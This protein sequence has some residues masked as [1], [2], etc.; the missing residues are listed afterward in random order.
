MTTD[1]D[2]LIMGGG[3]SGMT[4]AL[5]L[6][7]RMPSLRVMVL[8]RN[9]HPVP[10]AAHKVGEST[11]EIGAHYLA[12]TLGL[13]EHLDTHHLRKFGF[14]FFF[15]DG[16]SDIDQTTEL[17]ASRYLSAPTYQIDRGMLE[18]HLGQTVQAQGMTF[19]D[20]AVVQ[21]VAMSDH[22]SLPH[23]VTW[24][25]RSQGEK[26]NSASDNLSNDAHPVHT[27]TARWVIDASGR[28]GLLKRKFQLAE[29]ND[30]SAHAIWFRMNH[31]I[32][33]DAWSQDATW[34]QRCVKPERWL[35]TNHLCGPGY[36][37]WLIPL[38]SG[39]HSVDIVADPRLQPL[40]GMNTFERAMDWIKQHQPRL[41]QELDPVRDTLQDFAFFKSFSYGCKQVFSDQR[42]AITG[43][44]GRFLDPFYS[45][46]SD[47]IAIGNT[48]ITQ[49]VADDMA[50]KDIR[51]QARIYDSTI[52]TFYESMLPIYQDQ[53]ALFGDAEVMP[54]KVIWDYAYYWSVLAPLF[55]HERLTDVALLAYAQSDLNTC[56]RLN[57]QVQAFFR[58]WNTFSSKQGS[59]QMFDQ[60]RV[61]WFVE[62][63]RQLTVAKD[64]QTVRADLHQAAKLLAQ[65]AQEIASGA[66]ARHAGLADDAQLLLASTAAVGSGGPAAGTAVSAPSVTQS[67][68]EALLHA[69]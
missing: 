16:R 18:N 24:Q 48:Y 36:W 10:V 1:T 53:Y 62:L 49:L 67:P 17:G 13:R 68:R 7:K 46:G 41:H 9:A 30:H 59:A 5:Q 63:N 32:N 56:R 47:F 52:R 55:F 58:Q 12:D 27:T 40:E 34:Q 8:E 45:P 35:S 29:G 23:A 22:K 64:A 42:W 43:E 3:L 44:A 31:R 15:S 4:L 20:N 28:A 38:G 19:H 6:R 57:E 54:V 37:L 51:G 39:S 14:R 69:L 2:V 11:V 21:T 25:H 61:D 33:V 26:A 60:C 66:M 50:G 65:L